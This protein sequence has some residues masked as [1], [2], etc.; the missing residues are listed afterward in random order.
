MVIYWGVILNGDFDVFVFEMVVSEG[1]GV[2][3]S[4]FDW[5]CWVFVVLS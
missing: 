4:L 5:L 2:V 1:G 3:Y